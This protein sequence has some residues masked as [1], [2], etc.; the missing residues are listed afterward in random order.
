MKNVRTF[1]FLISILLTGCASVEPVPNNIRIRVFDH[2]TK[3]P[4]QYIDV[5]VSSHNYP[6]AAGI[7]DYYLGRPRSIQFG[8]DEYG[9]YSGYLERLGP[10][11]IML[12]NK[13]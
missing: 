8:T 10:F 12:R 6:F 11:S 5:F 2:E 13:E 3:K 7:A 9:Y 4:V 1:L